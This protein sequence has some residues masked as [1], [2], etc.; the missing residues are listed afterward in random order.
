M[1]FQ[2]SVEA[3]CWEIAGQG[4]KVPAQRMIDF[5]EG[6]KVKGFTENFLLSGNYFCSAFR[7]ATG[8]YVQSI[9]KRVLKLLNKNEGL[10]YK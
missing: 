5:V 1:Y 7:C 10:L 8:I 4:Q 3:K 9:K 2:K 6:D